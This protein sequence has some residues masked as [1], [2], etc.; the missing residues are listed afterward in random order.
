MGAPHFSASGLIKAEKVNAIPQRG[1]AILDVEGNQEL[2][3]A[4]VRRVCKQ[5]HGTVLLD[6]HFT[7]LKPDGRIEAIE[8][9]VFRALP[10]DA[11]VVY[12]DDPKKIA[13]RLSN[14][15]KSLS[16]PVAI[17]RHQRRELDQA[18]QVAAKLNVPIK[19]LEAFDE[20]SLIRLIS[21]R[22]AGEK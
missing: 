21:E 8:V 19:L 13:E 9:D 1:K 7:L 6:G 12:H 11:I 22:M 10:L 20:S 2:L 16:D 17:D 3:I 4:G 5:H 14:R 15:D 18:W